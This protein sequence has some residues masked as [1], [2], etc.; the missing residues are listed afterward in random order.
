MPSN[1]TNQPKLVSC[2]L[3]DSLVHQQLH[4]VVEIQNETSTQMYTPFEIGYN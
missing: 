4:Q 2:A 1:A 3:V